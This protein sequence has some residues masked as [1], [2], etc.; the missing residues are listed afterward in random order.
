[1]ETIFFL[2]VG[3]KFSN[4]NNIDSNGVMNSNESPF[5]INESERVQ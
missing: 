2:G 3:D 1:M 5:K 4:K